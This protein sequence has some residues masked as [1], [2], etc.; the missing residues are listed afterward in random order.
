[1][2]TS[3]VLHGH[4][5]LHGGKYQI[6]RKPTV[7]VCVDGFDL[8]YFET[9]CKDSILPNLISF[10]KSGF[11]ATAK[12]ATRSLTNR[13]NV[14][15]ITGI[16]TAGHGIVGN[17]YLEKKTLEEHMIHDHSLLRGST[18]LERIA[19]K[20]VR[21]AAIKAKDGLRK[22]INHGLLSSK[23]AICFPAQHANNTTE[24]EHGISDVDMAW[25]SRI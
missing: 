25:P 12:F 23:G 3:K 16:S 22:I 10:V 2:S 1:M 20:G 9:G 15:I 13:N 21:I 17:F 18:I 8:T 24:A 14:S 5:E 11:Y 6:P 4:V 19:N 7:V